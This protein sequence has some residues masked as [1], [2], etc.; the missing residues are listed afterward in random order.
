MSLCKKIVAHLDECLLKFLQDKFAKNFEQFDKQT[1]HLP[2]ICALVATRCQHSWGTS[3]KWSPVMA[4]GRSHVPCLEGV[5]PGPGQIPM[6]T[7]GS[8]LGLGELDPVD[9][10]TV[11]TE[12]ITFPQLYWKAVKIIK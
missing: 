12:N 7:S 1:A 2:T 3:L 4:S 9:R 8:G 6:A 11:M 5:G 10:M